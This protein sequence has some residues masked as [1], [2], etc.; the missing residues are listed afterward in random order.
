LFFNIFATITL[1]P[2]FVL[3]AILPDQTL[4]VVPS[5]W[6]WLMVGGQFLALIGLGLAFLQTAPF[7]FLGLAQLFAPQPAEHSPLIVSG[8]YNWVRHPLYTFS[9]LFI[10]LTPLMTVN[11]FV[12]YLLFTIYFYWGSIYEERR[13]IEE[14]GAEYEQYQQR[15][16]RLIPIPGRSYQ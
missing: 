6:R 7:H 9:L 10:W 15:V 5:P 14:F 1:L 8:F 13:L 11:L 3:W 4:Y 2:L 16:P 12:T